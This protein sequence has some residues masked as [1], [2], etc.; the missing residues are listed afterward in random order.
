MEKKEEKG[1]KGSTGNKIKKLQKQYNKILVDL[2][3]KYAAE[4]VEEALEATDGAFGQ[5]IHAILDQSLASLHSKIL[6][7]LG[8]EDVSVGG[9][10]AV[11]G[12]AIEGDSPCGSMDEVAEEEGELEEDEE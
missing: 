1:T 3:D 9:V 12:N 11:A 7:E 10:V 8:V 5:N 4:S 2:F 6:S